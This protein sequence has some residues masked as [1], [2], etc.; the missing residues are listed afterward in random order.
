MRSEALVL[1]EG[2]GAETKAGIRFNHRGVHLSGKI[3]GSLSIVHIR[4]Q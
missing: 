3:L 2:S 4:R 1:F